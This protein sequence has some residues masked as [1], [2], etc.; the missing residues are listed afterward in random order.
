HVDGVMIGR[1]AYRNPYFMAL[2]DHALFDADAPVPS[3][4]EVVMAM[5]GYIEHPRAAGGALKDITRHM[6]GLFHARPGGKNWRRQLSE[7]GHH[8]DAGWDI[9]ESALAVTHSHTRAIA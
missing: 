4:H 9:V 7:N 2:L 8:T 1:E 3:R 5:R 6:L